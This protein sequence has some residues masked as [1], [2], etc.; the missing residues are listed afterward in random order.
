M[1]KYLGRAEGTRAAVSVTLYLSH[2]HDHCPR[3]HFQSSASHT[4]NRTRTNIAERCV[5][6][7]LFALNGISLVFLNFSISAVLS[8]FYISEL[9]GYLPVAPLQ[10]PQ[11]RQPNKSRKLYFAKG[12]YYKNITIRDGSH[13]HI[14]NYNA[15]LLQRGSWKEKRFLYRSQNHCSRLTARCVNGPRPHRVCRTART[16]PGPVRRAACGTRASRPTP[17][18]LWRAGPLGE[19]AAPVRNLVTEALSSRTCTARVCLCE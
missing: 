14:F 12:K 4:R 2:T 6:G 11:V 15:W 17:C 13:F 16:R 5:H 8:T 18:S 19:P 7:P 3:I 1:D 9:A 10:Y